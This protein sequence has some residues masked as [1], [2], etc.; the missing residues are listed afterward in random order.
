MS[1]QFAN[2]VFH[3]LEEHVRLRILNGLADLEHEEL[4]VEADELMDMGLGEHV[5]QNIIG[6]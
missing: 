2:K 3:E 4:K 1:V 5:G 6:C